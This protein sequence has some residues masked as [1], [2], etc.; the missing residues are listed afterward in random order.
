MTT[1]SET[2]SLLNPSDLTTAVPLNGSIQVLFNRE[3][4]ERSLQHGGLIVEGPDGDAV[5]FPGFSPIIVYPG[6]EGQILESAGFAGLVPGE[7]TFERVDLVT[8]ANVDTEDT[9]GDGSLYRTRVLFKPT[10]PLRAQTEY[11]V[12]LIG[13]DE[14]DEES[15]LLNLSI[16]SRSV[17]DTVSTGNVGTSTVTFSGTY[18]GSLLNDVVNIRITTGGVVG[19]AEFEMWRDSAPLDVD[20]PFQTTSDQTLI[21]D[22]IGIKFTEGLFVVGD[23]YSVVVKRPVLFTGT[24]VYKFTT[25]NGSINVVPTTTST[26]ITGSPQLS[27]ASS[28]FAVV[29]ST[30]ENG[31][32]NLIASTTRRITVEFTNDIDPATIDTDSVKLTVESVS[33]HPL[34]P[35][36]ITAGDLSHRVTVSGKQLLIDL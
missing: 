10:Y 4:D 35:S 22:G 1:V 23:V 31:D 6:A 33:D 12:Y 3:I 16:R 2:L 29:S 8:S 34:L 11:T 21:P 17:F 19:E 28:R 32:T 14:D 20:G 30:P 15:D 7:F 27:A 13:E 5:I 24:T 9:T 26:S 36:R 25:G 18:T